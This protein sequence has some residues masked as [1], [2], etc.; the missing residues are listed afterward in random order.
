MSNREKDVILRGLGALPRFEVPGLLTGPGD[1][2]AVLD[3]QNLPLSVS[4]DAMVE[5]VHFTRTYSSSE[6]VGFK[7]IESSVSDLAAMGARPWVAF[8]SLA[9]P[10]SV[11]RSWLDGFWKGVAESCRRLTLQIVGGDTTRSPNDICLSATVL[12]VHEGNIVRRQGA[13]VGDEVYVTGTLGDSAAGLSI[14]QDI[15]AGRGITPVEREFLIEQ[16]LRPRARTSWGGWLGAYGEMSSCLDV[17]DGLL[18]DLGN[19]ADA[20]RVSFVIEAQ[21]LP[22]SPAFRAWGASMEESDR[23]RIALTGG[24]DYELVFT[25]PPETIV[26]QA[27]NGVKATRIGVVLPRAENGPD[28]RLHGLDESLLWN[29]RGWDPFRQSDL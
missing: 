1:D 19:M 11:E 9:L 26:P 4:K 15:G 7:L 29:E 17:S 5:G 2:A 18:Q 23:L 21:R 3:A 14:L 6:D 8:L 16:H 10:R 12:G 27:L 28:V 20:S 25:V 22:M 24:E 13:S